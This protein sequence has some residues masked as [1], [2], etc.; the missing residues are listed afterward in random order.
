MQPDMGSRSSIVECLK[1]DG[2]QLTPASERWA[3]ELEGKIPSE[4]TS[5]LVQRDGAARLIELLPKIIPPTEL[6]EREELG[7]WHLCGH[8]Y[9]AL[10]RYNEALGVISEMYDQMLLYQQRTDTRIHKGWP[11]IRM[12]ECHSNLNHPVLAKRY[13]MLTACEDAITGNGEILPEK[14]GVY[15]RLVW[16]CGFSHRLLSLKCGNCRNGSGLRVAFQNGSCR[17]SIRT[18]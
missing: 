13:F 2:Y 12:G 9:F 3:E 6:I 4:V 5:T 10:H 11:L 17:N 8:F 14:T 1:R 15:F 7:V 18:G 16:E